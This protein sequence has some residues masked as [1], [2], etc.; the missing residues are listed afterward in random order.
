MHRT[1][2]TLTD[3]QYEHLRRESEDSGLSMAEIVRRKL[4]DAGGES[5]IAMRRAAL[6]ESAG[7]WTDRDFDGEEYVEQIRGPG[8][9]ERLAKY[10]R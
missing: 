7:A 3:S 5:G 4:D 1:Q 6:R 9:G 10:G 2:I 8:L